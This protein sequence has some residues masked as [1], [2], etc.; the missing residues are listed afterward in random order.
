MA[1]KI[2]APNPPIHELLEEQK[3]IDADL[4][5]NKGTLFGPSMIQFNTLKA[6]VDELDAA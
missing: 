4:R 1:D 5:Q 6:R 2:Y 3:A